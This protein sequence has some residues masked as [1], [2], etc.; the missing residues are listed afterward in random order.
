MADKKDKAF[1][2]LLKWQ[3]QQLV[4][5]FVGWQEGAMY[6]ATKS[7]ASVHV[8]CLQGSVLKV[9]LFFVPQPCLFSEACRS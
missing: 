1:A 7:A 2:A 9:P 3:N 8:V 6:A 4:Y 5:A